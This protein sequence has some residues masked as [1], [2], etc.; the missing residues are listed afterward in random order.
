MVMIGDKRSHHMNNSPYVIRNY[1][2][3]D[4][5]AL[6]H[7]AAEMGKGE[8]TS[9]STQSQDLIETLGRPHHSPESNLFVAEKAG[10]II[11]CTDLTVE[12]SIERVVLSC[13]VHPEYRGRGC[14][15]KL[16][17]RAIGRARELKVG[18]VHVNIPEDNLGARKLLAKMGFRCVRHFLELELDLSWPQGP[19][20]GVSPRCR[21][22]KIGEE[23]TLVHIQNRS[24]AD[25]WGFNPNTVEEIAY[26]LCLPNRGPED[27]ILAYDGDAVVGYC[28]TRI[29]AGRDKVRRDDKG[30]IYML[31]VDPDHRGKGIGKEV[32]LA[33]LSYLRSKGLGI[34]ELTVDSKNEPA[35]ALYRSAGFQA[36]MRS[37]WY[38]KALG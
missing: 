13:L 27:V 29:Y 37:L 10:D 12:L 1:R 35:L 3:G 30:R 20:G 22:L 26:R 24:F 9:G 16:M 31:G 5:G 8:R 14:A 11:G 34:I 7:L 23:D 33:G 17:D 25:T 21:H 18:R 32:L 38:E 4:Y 2:P 28:W 36:R 19:M 15:A 6:V